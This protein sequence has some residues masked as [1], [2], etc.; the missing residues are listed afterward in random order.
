MASLTEIGEWDFAAAPSSPRSSPSANGLQKTHGHAFAGPQWAIL[1]SK[2]PAAEHF[3]SLW[4][5]TGLHISRISLV[6]EA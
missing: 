2:H 5:R 4:D 1:G 3:V 6:D